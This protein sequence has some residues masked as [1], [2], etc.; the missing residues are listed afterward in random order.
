[1]QTFHIQQSISL[2][3]LCP[4]FR[5]NMLYNILSNQ[6][7]LAAKPQKYNDIAKINGYK[8][9]ILYLKKLILSLFSGL[10]S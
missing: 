2:F 3:L 9:P 7:Q 8:Q 6:Y 5:N 10:P 1:M 4:F